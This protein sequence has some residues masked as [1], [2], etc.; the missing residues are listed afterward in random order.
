METNNYN[1]IDD[2]GTP[3]TKKTFKHQNWIQCT[4]VVNDVDIEYWILPIPID[5]PDDMATYLISSLEDDAVVLELDS[6]EF[7]VEMFG[8]N[9]LGTCSSEEQIQLLYFALTGTDLIETLSL[10]INKN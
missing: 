3:I 10:K 6:G 5:N 7:I 9:G 1:V 4:D 8:L 2:L